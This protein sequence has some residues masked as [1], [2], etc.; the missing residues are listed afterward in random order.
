MNTKE[1]AR[2]RARE[3]AREIV[4]GGEKKLAAV[5]NEYYFNEK[6]YFI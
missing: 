1:H 5:Q 3:R 2:K 4:R 6:I